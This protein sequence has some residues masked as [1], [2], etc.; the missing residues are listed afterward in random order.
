MSPIT[1]LVMTSPIPSNP[2]ISMIKATITSV[3]ERL[4]DAKIIILCDG[5]RPEQAEREPAYDEFLWT[6]AEEYHIPTAMMVQAP[7]F[8]HQSGML[9]NA[10]PA[11]QTP[12]VLVMEHDT[13]LV[14]D[15]PFDEIVSTMEIDQINS[16][17]FMH[18]THIL[19]GHEHLFL[20]ND[21]HLG[22]VPYR[23][24]IQWSQRP[25][26]ARTSWYQN[27]LDTYFGAESRT[28]IEDLMHGVVQHDKHGSALNPAGAFRRWRMAVYAPEGSW[29]RSEHFDGRGEDPK[30]PLKYAYDGDRPSDAPPE[31]IVG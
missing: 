26:V 3:Q 13:P 11:V 2:D 20:P 12:Y 5:V 14:G 23:R 28:F 7:Q 4:S 24:T 1:V 16:M 8:W 15:I 9:K 6:L 17:R 29:K 19:E 21:F 22:R 30:F 27:I 18:E 10:M 31:G 25:H